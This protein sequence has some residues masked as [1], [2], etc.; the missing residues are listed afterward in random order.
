M[1]D[2]KLKL[3]ELGV[4]VEA[5]FEWPG[6]SDGTSISMPEAASEISERLQALEERLAPVAL[7]PEAPAQIAA[8]SDVA[9]PPDRSASP[10]EIAHVTRFLER[11]E[12]RLNAAQSV[13][14]IEE[15]AAVTL[16]LEAL[17]KRA[18]ATPAVPELA[19]IVARLDALD[20][21]LAQPSV[22]AADVAAHSSRLD[23][24][25]AR[26]SIPP[27]LSSDMNETVARLNSLERRLGEPAPL[28]AEITEIP[29]RLGALEQRLVDQPLPSASELTALTLR[30]AALEEWSATLPAV[31]AEMSGVPA[32]LHAIEQH[33][34]GRGPSADELDA[35]TVRLEALE[36]RVAAA[37][38]V[39]D[40]TNMMARLVA[41]EEQT[42]RPALTPSTVEPRPQARNGSGDEPVYPGR[43]AY[44]PDDPAEPARPEL[45][46]QGVTR[47]G[48]P[49]AVTASTE[50]LGAGHQAVE[51]ATSVGQT[52]PGDSHEIE[53][54]GQSPGGGERTGGVDVELRSPDGVL[55]PSPS[56][57][58]NE[59]E[60]LELLRKEI[61]SMH[62]GFGPL[63]VAPDSSTSQV[64]AAAE[65]DPPAGWQGRRFKKGLRR[66]E[67]DT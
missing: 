66:G 34:A 42:N 22:S 13:S 46:D 38:P 4:R 30:M 12:Q 59:A 32:R 15:I 33:L 18:V 45:F 9:D 29:T 58:E 19:G 47:P 51:R 36:S 54:T 49:A 65:P 35:L 2:E 60:V 41:L 27:W 1:A 48:E 62:S 64:H 57:A 43:S 17:E 44:A 26:P 56:A 16:R 55:A 8:V 20:Q 23:A 21:R 10:S 6:Q 37:A 28:P 31:P 14:P 25:E 24:L 7:G 11:L 5:M 53:A 61:A 39:S 63:T 50:T 67:P 52:R 3:K 40:V